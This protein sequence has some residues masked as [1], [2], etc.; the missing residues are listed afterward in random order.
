MQITYTL[1]HRIHRLLTGIQPEV[2]NRSQS[3]TYR[4]NLVQEMK[5]LINRIDA[6]A[7]D[8]ETLQVDYAKLKNSEIYQAYR[9]LSAS[10]QGFDLHSLKTTNEK[11]AFWINLYNLLTIDAVIH[12]GV[13]NNINE[14]KGVFYKAGYNIGGCFFGLH[15]IEQGILRANT[16]HP[17]VPGPQFASHD[18]RSQHILPQ[19]DPRVHFALVCAADSCPPI[20]IYNAE[21]IDAQLDLAT[22][23]FINS[24]EVKIDPEKKRANL[25][26]IFQWYA[27]DFG[28]SKTVTYG[29]G[30]SAPILRWLADYRSNPDEQ[31]L[32]KNQADEFSIRFIDYNWSLNQAG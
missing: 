21:N 19:L 15:D 25:S 13:E 10:L 28:A 6:E 22:R 27:P 29:F 14:V 11:L 9:D 31:S 4:A 26:K 3:S 20:N 8:H 1:P 16:G 5:T 24:S 2:L 18:P 7:F 32:L 23:N 30:D 17:A 12:Y